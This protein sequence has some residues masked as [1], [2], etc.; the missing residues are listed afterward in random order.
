M[1]HSLFSSA[2]L[3]LCSSA[4][5]LPISPLIS[6]SVDRLS[7]NGGAGRV[8]LSLNRCET[9]IFGKTRP[10]RFYGRLIGSD[11]TSTPQRFV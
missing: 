9:S 6:N 7:L 11:I 3:L 10:Y 4:P 5:Y 8:W 1:G 2:P